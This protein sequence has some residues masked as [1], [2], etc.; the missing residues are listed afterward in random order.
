MRTITILIAGLAA[1]AFAA[2]ASAA[3]SQVKLRNGS[4]GTKLLTRDTTALP[5]M[6]FAGAANQIWTRT[7]TTECCNCG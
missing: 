4:T 5:S 6:K 1:L 3:T 2:P 7:D